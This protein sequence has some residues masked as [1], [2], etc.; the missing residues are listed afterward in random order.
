[1][2]TGIGKVIFNDPDATEVKIEA[3]KSILTKQSYPRYVYNQNSWW[4][5]FVNSEDAFKKEIIYYKIL[6]GNP[7]RQRAFRGSIPR[8]ARNGSAATPI[9]PTEK[10]NTFFFKRQKSDRKISFV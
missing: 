2:N 7:P 8:S 9:E 10:P 4:K 3:N 1:M 5:H 6:S